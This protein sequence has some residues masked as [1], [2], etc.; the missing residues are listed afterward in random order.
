MENN[1]ER[2]NNTNTENERI[3]EKQRIRSQMSEGV[4]I[5]HL[6]LGV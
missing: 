5:K 2:N 6:Y 3:P 1:I 4:Q